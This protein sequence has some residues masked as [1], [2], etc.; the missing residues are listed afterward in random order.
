M[1][2]M[3]EGGQMGW[4]VGDCLGGVGGCLVGREILVCKPDRCTCVR[5]FEWVGR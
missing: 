4:V 3:V 1:F 2:E 5:L